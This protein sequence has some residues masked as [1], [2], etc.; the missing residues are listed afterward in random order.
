VN[1]RVLRAFRRHQIKPPAMIHRFD[2]AEDGK[3][4]VE[5]LRGS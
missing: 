5:A 1:R 2:L 3:A 4:M